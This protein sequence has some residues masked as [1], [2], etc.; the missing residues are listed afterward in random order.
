MSCMCLSY[1]KRRGGKRSFI[2]RDRAS[3]HMSHS[4]SNVYFLKSVGKY[5]HL[6]WHTD[7]TLLAASCHSGRRKDGAARERERER[8]SWGEIKGWRWCEDTSPEAFHPSCFSFV[9]AI[10]K[11]HGSLKGEGSTSER[12]RKKNTEGKARAGVI[13][14]EKSD[15]PF[16]TLMGK[17]LN[18]RG[19]TLWFLMHYPE[20]VHLAAPLNIN[21]EQ[22]GLLCILWVAL[23]AEDRMFA[24]ILLQYLLQF[25]SD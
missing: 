24:H 15:W 10:T 17:L 23:F 12:K 13:R 9:S 7:R 22:C 3:A 19:K 6:G 18:M 1:E 21:Y 2:K 4:G 8:E 25:S 16:F 20:W 11:K 14:E 5:M